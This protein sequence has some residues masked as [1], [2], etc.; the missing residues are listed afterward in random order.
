[1][2]PKNTTTTKND[3]NPSNKLTGPAFVAKSDVYPQAWPDTTTCAAQTTAL[4]CR[5][6]CSSTSVSREPS[7]RDEHKLRSLAAPWTQLLSFSTTERWAAHMRPLRPSLWVSRKDWMI[8]QPKPFPRPEALAARKD[9]Y[10]GCFAL[11]DTASGYLDFCLRQL[12][13]TKGFTIQLVRL[14]S[15]ATAL[16]LRFCLVSDQLSCL[17]DA[18][19]LPPPLCSTDA[20]LFKCPSPKTLGS[21][22]RPPS[23]KGAVVSETWLRAAARSRRDR[24]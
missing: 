15:P 5:V 18:P 9:R 22:Y 19:R 23:K 13:D 11:V 20:D 7:L 4:S 6:H 16:I 8:F 17:H 12:Q 2:A 1:M 3:E 10:D 21:G 14:Q 24:S